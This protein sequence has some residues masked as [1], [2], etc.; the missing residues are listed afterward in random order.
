[1]TNR[2]R[3]QLGDITAMNVDAVVNS[4]DNTLRAGGPVHV[5]VH[6]AAGPELAR[7]CSEAGDCPVGQARI[8]GGHGLHAPFIL[9]TVA[10]IWL[11]G[12]A[13]E[14]EALADCYRSCLLLAELQGI[15]TVAFPSLGAGHQ[16]QFPLEQAA[17]VAVHT[18]LDFLAGHAVPR[19]VILV[20]FDMA[21]YQ[22]HQNTLK[23]ALP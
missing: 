19:Q 7:E 18:I 4:T 15:D 9:H 11:G 13:G 14:K 8:T 1:M 20:C 5:A 23:E 21:S 22:I 17:P 3:L 6:R 10:P 2:L 12:M 16:P